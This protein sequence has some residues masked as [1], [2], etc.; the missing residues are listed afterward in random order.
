MSCVHNK[1]ASCVQFRGLE[2]G[3]IVSISFFSHEIWK[4]CNNLVFKNQALPPPQV[5][6]HRASDFAYKF[7][8]AMN[9]NN[10]IL[11]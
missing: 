7:V 4:D 8:K 2:W 9:L 5:I 1:L 3:I 6:L 10:V 11:V